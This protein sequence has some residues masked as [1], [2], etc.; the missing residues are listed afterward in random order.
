MSTRYI[1]ARIIHKEYLDFW[2]AHLLPIGLPLL[3]GLVL[4]SLLAFLIVREY[5]ILACVI[6]L[7]V[8]VAILVN[9]Y[10]FISVML[11]M[12]VLPFIPFVG[13]YSLVYWVFHRT[14]ILMALGINVISRMLKLK[15]HPS[16][17]LG[18][19]ELAMFAFGVFALLSILL[20]TVTSIKSTL[21]LYDRTLVPF[22]AYLLMRFLSPRGTDLKRLLPIMFLVGLAECVIGLLSL[23]APQTIPSIWHSDLLGDRAVGTLGEPGVYAS[24]LIFLMVFL[25]HDAMNR[26]RGT[27][28]IILVLTFGLGM[29]CIL[30]T[31]TRSCWLAGLV[32]LLGLLFIYPKAIFSLILIV[33]PIMLILGGGMLAKEFAYGFE[34]LNNKGTAEGRIIQAHAGQE[35]FYAKPFFGWGYESYDHYDW[36]FMERVGNVAPK[37]WDIKSGTSHNTYLTMLAE[38]GAV[39]FFF[40]FFP[41]IW[42]LGLTV[43]VL[44]KLP[45]EGFWSRRL[46]V[47]AWLS[48]GAQVV[49]SQF[50]DMR[51]FLLPFTTLWFTL[52]LIASIVQNYLEPNG[53]GVARTIAPRL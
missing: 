49:I 5:W 42:W 14:L 33:V 46:L 4:G 38:M 9:R 6:V 25:F 12:A 47:V 18:R 3:M 27:V 51:F 24:V 35:M 11:W 19:A 39:G 8:P 16:V 7:L 10:P 36:K 32:V 48:V 40:Y 20:S 1:I 30:F 21:T 44:P 43:K 26:E 50:I 2:K 22:T 29:V 15:S 53:I 17:R 34:R 23:F 41:L 31:F 13:K 45:K 52:G 28:R 37:D